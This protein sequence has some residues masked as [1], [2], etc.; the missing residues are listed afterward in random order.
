MT[1]SAITR[2]PSAPATAS[3]TFAKTSAPPT[4]SASRRRIFRSR[5]VA[6]RP[7]LFRTSLKRASTRCRKRARSIP[8]S[9]R[10]WAPSRAFRVGDTTVFPN[11]GCAT[12]SPGVLPSQFIFGLTVPRKF[13]VPNTQQWNLTDP[14]GA[15]QELG[16]RSR[17]RRNPRRSSARNPHQHSSGAGQPDESLLPARRKL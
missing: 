1:C 13:V 15:R 8:T 14:A 6:G 16:A 2:P 7:A 10:A 17:L 12:G 4:S 11:Y 5:S 3:T 9:F